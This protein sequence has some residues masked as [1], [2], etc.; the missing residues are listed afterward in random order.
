[1]DK[2]DEALKL[3]KNI[4]HIDHVIKMLQEQI[5]RLYTT[6]TNATVKPKDIN[7]QSSLPSDP[8]ADLVIQAIEYQKQVQEYQMEL[9]NSKNKALEVIRRM[10]IDNQQLLLLRYFKGYSVEE[11][12][13]KVGYTYRWAWERIHEAEEEFIG[14]YEKTT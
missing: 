3:L 4:R 9:I 12:G 14:L 11:V 13:T 8:M 10:D 7:V 2:Q 6:L 5:D 1:M